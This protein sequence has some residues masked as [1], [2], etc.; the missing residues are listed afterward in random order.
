MPANIAMEIT[1]DTQLPSIL[2]LI[3][4]L[5]MNNSNGETLKPVGSNLDE[6]VAMV[7]SLGLTT[8]LD[9]LA[10][11]ADLNRAE[12][13][14]LRPFAHLPVIRTAMLGASQAVWVLGGPECAQ[15]ARALAVMIES[16][17]Y[18]ISYN[19]A[20][21]GADFLGPQFDE[22]VFARLHEEIE[23][24]KK[25]KEKLQK[26]MR[27][28]NLKA[29][30]EATQMHLSAAQMCWSGDDP[31]SRLMKLAVM[32][33]WKISSSVAHARH[34]SLQNRG[35]SFELLQGRDTPGAKFTPSAGELSNYLGL[36]ALMLQEGLRLWRDRNIA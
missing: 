27:D 12:T 15:H 35:R 4:E 8:A 11:F 29:T 6:D 9:C 5:T 2:S 25:Q 17:K 16:L 18:E 26:Q 28:N 36:T 10:L 3:G 21:E 30:A 19:E 1:A 23:D 34:W 20:L 32:T 14:V 33:Q 7:A 24:L 13:F 31:E 22:G